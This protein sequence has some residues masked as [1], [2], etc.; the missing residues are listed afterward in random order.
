MSDVPLVPDHTVT[1]P[2]YKRFNGLLEWIATVDHKQ[3]GLLYV[4]GTFFFFLV[5]GVEALLMRIQLMQP[6]MRFLSPTDYNQI[7]TMHGVTMIFF[8]VMPMLL[9][10]ANYVV[11]LQIGARDMAYPRLNA[12]SFWMFVSG[13]VILYYSFLAGG[14]PDA[15]WF[16]YV[17]LSGQPYTSNVGL[18]YYCIGILV[19]GIGTVATALNLLVTI[20]LYRAPG[21]SMRRLPLFTWMTMFNSFLIMFAMPPLNASL[22]MLL[23]DRKLGGHFFDV[24]AGASPLLWQ[25]YFWTFGHPEVYIMILPAWGMISEIIPV[26]SRKPIFGYGIVAASTVAIAFLSFAVWGHHMFSSGMGPAADILF[27]LGSLLIAVPTGIKVFNWVATAWGGK[28]R[29]TTSMLFALAFVVQ[30][31]AG[32]VTGVQLGVVPF[33]RYVTDTYFI[34]AHFHYVLFG[35]TAFGLFAAFY[36][37]FPKAF[38]R[39]LNEKI[40]K[41][42]FWL[43][44]VGFNTAF[45]VQHALGWM[46]MTRRIWTYPDYP[47]WGLYNMISTVGSFILAFG[48]LV[49]VYNVFYSLKKGE[50]AGENPWDA[51]TLEWATTSPPPHYNFVQ[52]PPVRSRRPLWDLNHPDQ[53]DK[54]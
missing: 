53:A 21:V 4:M 30:F 2:S 43:M 18:D 47:G 36:Y 35:G 41:W 17:P 28:I 27:S 7:F 49:F 29:F 31:T 26:F 8:V 13:G 33:D 50:V 48:V 6:E 25:H 15:G 14:A 37:W 11:P 34:V 1:M 23:I 51:W 38:G 16:A 24:L 42:N 32:G 52:V 9:G 19:A 12:L 54:D 44:F 46:G 22:I 39:M 3:I 5:G 20:F 10:V 40:G 45:F